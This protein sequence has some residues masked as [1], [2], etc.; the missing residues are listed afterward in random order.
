L[1]ERE[2]S[3]RRLPQL[4]LIGQ[5]LY[6]SD[7]MSIVQ[8]ATTWY[9]RTLAHGHHTGK[10]TSFSVIIIPLDFNCRLL[11]RFSPDSAEQNAPGGTAKY[12]G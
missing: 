7:V 3:D 12:P 11:N 4:D 2:A 5:Y 9:Y 8:P 6:T 1:Q 10:T